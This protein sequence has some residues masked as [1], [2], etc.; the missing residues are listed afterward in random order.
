MKKLLNKIVIIV[1]LSSNGNRTEWSTIL[2]I[3]GREFYREF[4]PSE[5]AYLTFCADV[6]KKFTPSINTLDS[7]LI[8]IA[9]PQF[10]DVALL[11]YKI[12]KST[13]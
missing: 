13:P 2:R 7:S 9:S 5:C 6:S 3:M 10:V 11:T 4:L 1:I 12:Y 8:L